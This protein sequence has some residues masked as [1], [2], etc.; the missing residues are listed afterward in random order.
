MKIKT[1]QNTIT[2]L[3]EDTKKDLWQ[4]DQKNSGMYEDEPEIARMRGLLDGYEEVKKLLIKL[5]KN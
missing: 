2:N 3:I 1:L 4:H 5:N